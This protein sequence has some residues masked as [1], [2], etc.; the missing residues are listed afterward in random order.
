MLDNAINLQ[1]RFRYNELI[2]E[3][4]KEQIIVNNCVIEKIRKSFNHNISRTQFSNLLK[5]IY[6]DPIYN[7]GSKIALDSFKN[8]YINVDDTYIKFKVGNNKTKKRRLR[9]FFFHQGKN[10]NNELINGKYIVILKNHDSLNPVQ[11]AID[12]KN[13]TLRLIDKFYTNQAKS[14][15]LCS[16]GAKEFK[17]LAKA[18]NAKQILDKYHLIHQNLHKAINPT[19]I[20]YDNVDKSVRKDAY[21]DIKQCSEKTPEL[22]ITTIEKYRQEFLDTNTN[23]V[24]AK[25][26]SKFKRYVINNLEGIIN[27]QSED[28]IYPITEQYIFHKIK[29]VLGNKNKCYSLKTFMTFI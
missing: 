8:L 26:L 13:E 16:D 19:K 22:L 15:I 2:L 28:Y 6:S 24:I 9:L 5:R 17:Y 27:W 1:R 10:E 18:L 12:N 23:S 14:L 29:S 20:L 7:K 11:R 21:D 25:A 4:I 3:A